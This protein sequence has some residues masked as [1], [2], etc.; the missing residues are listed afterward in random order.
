[1]SLHPHPLEPA[2]EDTARAAWA[3]IPAGD[4]VTRDRDEPEDRYA[5]GEGVHVAA[6]A[7]EERGE[8]P[9]IAEIAGARRVRVSGAGAQS[10]GGG[11]AGRCPGPRGGRGGT[12]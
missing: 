5:E 1:M 2:P 12:R 9:E 7:A 3:I 6:V 10:G 4:P 11:Y 8:R